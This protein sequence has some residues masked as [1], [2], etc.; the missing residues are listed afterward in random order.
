MNIYSV[1]IV[2]VTGYSGREAD[3][4]LKYHPSVKVTGRF[5]S[6]SDGSGIEAYAWT[7]SNGG[8]PDVVIDGD[9]T[10]RFPPDCSGACCRADS[11]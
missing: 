8:S 10:R 9:G 4:L 1:A 2:G 3:R 11:A 6:K 7:R 5:A